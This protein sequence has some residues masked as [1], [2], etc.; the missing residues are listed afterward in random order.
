MVKPLV[1]LVKEIDIYQRNRIPETEEQKYYS[2]VDQKLYKKEENV[3][4]ANDYWFRNHEGN[5]TTFGVTFTYGGQIVILDRLKGTDRDKVLEHE[6]HHRHNPS[7]SEFMTRKKTCTEEFY[8]NPVV[9]P[10]G[11]Y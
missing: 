3:F 4:E 8:P 2:P 10:I 11:V 7:D 6:K 5:G 9:S 1:N